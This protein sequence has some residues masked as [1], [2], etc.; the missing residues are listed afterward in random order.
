VR[1]I[2]DDDSIDGQGSI[3]LEEAYTLVDP[4][5][6]FDNAS[7]EMRSISLIGMGAIIYT[8]R[9]VHPSPVIRMKQR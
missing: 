9:S 5:F 7:I 3:G 6:A 8:S 1:N 4:T 2:R